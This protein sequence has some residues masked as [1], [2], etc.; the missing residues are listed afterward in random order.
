MAKQGFIGWGVLLLPAVLIGLVVWSSVQDRP[1]PAFGRVLFAVLG[2]GVFLY[3]FR[4]PIFGLLQGGAQVA[5]LVAVG[6]IF[7]AIIIS[8]INK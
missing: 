1:W 4:G 6:A 8:F 2:L 7:L 3:L 5:L